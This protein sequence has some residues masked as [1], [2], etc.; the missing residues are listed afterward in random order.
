MATTVLGYN[1]SP[2]GTATQVLG[3]GTALVDKDGNALT[4][5][6]GNIVVS[7]SLKHLATTP[8]PAD[9]AGGN[10]ADA[11]DV[12]CG[13]TS[14]LKGSFVD[15][16]AYNHISAEGTGAPTSPALAKT[17]A[18]PLLIHG[19]DDGT[20]DADLL[21]NGAVFCCLLKYKPMPTL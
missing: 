15:L 12:R 9:G 8:A 11:V 19:L 13:A 14:L 1:R 16:L 21:N 7:I 2:S 6:S 18:G 4:L 20:G 10:T 17:T 3:V 5:P